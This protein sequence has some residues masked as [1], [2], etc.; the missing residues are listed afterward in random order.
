MAKVAYTAIQME[1]P[2]TAPKH[3]ITV[4]YLENYVQ[5]KLKNPVRVVSTSNL[6]GTYDPG[7]LP[8]P[9]TKG[10]ITLGT[11]GALVVDGVTLSL[12]DRILI[13]GQT[14]GEENGIYVVVEPGDSTTEA[15]IQRADDFDE[16]AEI[17]TGVRVAIQEGTLFAASTW[18]LTTAGTII[19]DST[20][21]DFIQVENSTGAEK[22]CKTITGDNVKSNFEVEHFLGTTDVQVQVY[23]LTTNSEVIVD[24]MTIDN[25]TIDIG[26]GIIPTTSQSF[27]VVIVG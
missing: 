26:F 12:A 23:N 20:A 10:T 1:A 14:N 9:I 16:S 24:V 5:G 21:L 17:F 25:D 27:R 7:V 19:L 22:V 6:S 2:I 8:D 15:I 3:L 18:A 4:E 13:A 11:T